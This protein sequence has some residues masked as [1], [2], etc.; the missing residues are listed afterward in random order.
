ME[1]RAALIQLKAVL[2]LLLLRYRFEMAQPAE[3]YRND[4]QALR[5][6]SGWIK[7]GTDGWKPEYGARVGRL[8][9][10]L[11]GD[12]GSVCWVGLPMPRSPG[13]RKKLQTINEVVEEN[14]QGLIGEPPVWTERAIL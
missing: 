4:T 14:T 1:L 13:Y 3:T 10:V 11:T 5:T 9:D 6:D 2:S 8:L 12:G 7:W